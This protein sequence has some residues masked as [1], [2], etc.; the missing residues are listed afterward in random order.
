MVDQKI[1]AGQF[2][3]SMSQV[4]RHG[5]F[6]LQESPISVRRI[7]ED[8]WWKDFKIGVF[9]QEVQHTSFETFVTKNVPEG[10]ETTVHVLKAMCQDDP[11]VLRLIDRELGLEPSVQLQLNARAA[12]RAIAAR[13]NREDVVSLLRELVKLV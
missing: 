3:T 1:L 5:G 4:C 7:I 10:L 13:H 12:A 8:N 6:Y 2:I 9:N 11:E